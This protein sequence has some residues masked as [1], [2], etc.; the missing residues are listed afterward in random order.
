M[1]STLV[2]FN[3]KHLV[4]GW[5]RDPL[6]PLW[7]RLTSPKPVDYAA[8]VRVRTRELQPLL[9]DGRLLADFAAERPL[10]PGFGHGLDER[11]VEFPW[12]VAHLQAVPARM[13]DVGSTLNHEFLLTQECFTMRDLTIVTLEPEELCFS[14]RRI[15]YVYD[16]ARSLPFRDGWFD[17]VVSISTLE[18]IG[19][20]N[21]RFYSQRTAYREN[22]RSSYLLALKEMWRVLKPGGICLLTVPFGQAADYTWFQQFDGTMVDEMIAT[23]SPAQTSE[24]YYRYLGGSWRLCT[25]GECADAMSFHDEPGAG[26]GDV[27]KA[28]G[29][30]VALKMN[31]VC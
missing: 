21:T 17:E 5:I 24:T 6:R 10:P 28:S 16:D 26:K 31:K 7:K 27:P 4:P 14:Q 25:R 1:N 3:W 30:I 12:L 18:H 23:L 13:L 8:Y 2:G 11:I 19:L 9:A 29:A 20:D 22:D 15:S